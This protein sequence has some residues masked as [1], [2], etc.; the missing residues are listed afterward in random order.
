MIESEGEDGHALIYCTDVGALTTRGQLVRM[1]LFPTAVRFK[2]MDQ[3]P[4]ASCM[5]PFR[6]VGTCVET[7]RR[8]IDHWQCVGRV[9]SQGLWIYVHLCNPCFS[10]QIGLS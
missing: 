3:L 1:V 5:V 2:Y 4:I 9:L 7:L 6:D 10:L 8:R